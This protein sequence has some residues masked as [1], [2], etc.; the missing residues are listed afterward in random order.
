MAD[1]Q[2]LT[3]WD[4]LVLA[5]DQGVNPPRGPN[6]EAILA[7]PRSYRGVAPPNAPLG[8]FLLGI[9]LSVP[10]GYYNGQEGEEGVFRIHPWA[11]TPTNS[12][13]LASWL[14]GLIHN[15]QFTLSGHTMLQGR[16]TS[17][18]GPV[19]DTEESTAWQSMVTYTVQSLE[20]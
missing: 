20:F 6:N 12:K 13:K 18:D 5:I 19:T 15:R 16:V 11:T 10:F 4:E 1:L 3:V 2:A 17:I 7:S 8:Y 9:A 14:R